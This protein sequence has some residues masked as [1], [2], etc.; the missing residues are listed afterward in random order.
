MLF[1][2]SRGVHAWPLGVRRMDMWLDVSIQPEWTS[3][4][5]VLLAKLS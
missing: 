2:N 5:M 3:K 4:V 1:L